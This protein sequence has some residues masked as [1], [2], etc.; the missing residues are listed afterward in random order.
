MPTFGR[1]K[2]AFNQASNI[3][4]QLSTNTT[5]VQVKFFVSINADKSYDYISFSTV[6]SKVIVQDL[7][8]GAPLNITFG[9]A[10]AIEGDYE[11]LWIIGDDEPIPSGAINRICSEIENNNF[12]FLIGS[13]DFIGQFDYKG[14]YAHISKKAKGTIS[15][16]TSTVYKTSL[17][18]MHDINAA[19][20]FHL[21]HFPH[22]VIFNKI[23]QR[24]KNLKL[25]FVPLLSLCRVDMRHNWIG[26]KTPR[27]AF[28][29]ED[30]IVFF[31]KPLA[32]L[33]VN[34]EVYQKRELFFWWLKNWHRVHMFKYNK[35]IRY[36]MLVSTSLRYSRNIPFIML[37]KLPVW[38][39]KDIIRPIK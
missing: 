18:N 31:G 32:I 4:E 24:E 16:V 3:F 22:L 7:N 36:K 21:S 6:S 11:Y 39:L 23:I 37:A 12:D 20:D 25:I 1:S 35:D 26:S 10:Q 5:S 27:N 8:V 30:S 13:N 17:F 15:F 38:R 9:F 34:S 14:S 33:A 28:G 2:L 29:Y 19:I